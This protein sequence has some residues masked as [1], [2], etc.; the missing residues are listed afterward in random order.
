MQTIMHVAQNNPSGVWAR[1][2]LSLVIGWLHLVDLLLAAARGDYDA[3][4]SPR[5]QALCRHWAGILA[6]AR[7]RGRLVSVDNVRATNRV[8]GECSRALTPAVNEILATRQRAHHSAEA[9]ADFFG[10]RSEAAQ[11]LLMLCPAL[12]HYGLAIA[13]AKYSLENQLARE[14]EAQ[15]AMN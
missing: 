12:E 2:H 8:L 13:A 5:P 11:T 7:P 14:T 1:Y 3:H 6:R 9:S 15:A 4:G 10:W